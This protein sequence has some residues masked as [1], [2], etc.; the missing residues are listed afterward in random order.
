MRDKRQLPSAETLDGRLIIDEDA[1]RL[2]CRRLLSRKCIRTVPYGKCFIT[3]V[4]NVCRLRGEPR[5][6]IRPVSSKIAR[7][8]CSFAP[9]NISLGD[10]PCGI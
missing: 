6:G 4:R 10:F 8:T 7:C 1:M 3:G 5:V 9:G 2:T